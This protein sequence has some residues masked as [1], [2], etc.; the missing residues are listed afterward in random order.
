MISIMHKYPAYNSSLMHEYFAP[1]SELCTFLPI[2][3]NCLSIMARYSG[4]TVS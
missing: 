3:R 4:V 2:V 1:L